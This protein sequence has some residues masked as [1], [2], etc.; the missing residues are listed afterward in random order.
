MRAQFIDFL[1]TTAKELKQI[2]EKFISEMFEEDLEFKEESEYYFCDEDCDE[3]QGK[4]V[5]QQ[6]DT[7]KKF[8]SKRRMRDS[9]VIFQEQQRLSDSFVKK[10]KRGSSP[11]KTR[12]DQETGYACQ[13]SKLIIKQDAIEQSLLL[14]DQ[15]L[16][17]ERKAEKEL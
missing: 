3:C 6:E 1:K 8:C 7:E 4:V 13:N 5:I 12:F 11:L 14:A 9:S 16:E 15:E 17:A 2:G 10:S